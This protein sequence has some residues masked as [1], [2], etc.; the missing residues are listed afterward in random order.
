M[1]LHGRWSFVYGAACQ[2]AT[3][4]AVPGQT[5][6][7]GWSASPRRGRAPL[8]TPVGVPVAAVLPGARRSRAHR[9]AAR[10]GR[11]PSGARRFFRGPTR[12]A[13][14]DTATAKRDGWDDL[15]DANLDQDGVARAGRVIPLEVAFIQCEQHFGPAW[16]YAPLRWG[17]SDGCVPFT[18][19][20]AY[21]AALAM[22][23]ARVSIDTAR[24]IGL[25][26]GSEDAGKRAFTAAV[27]E[28]FPEAVEG[29]SDG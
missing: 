22:G 13:D 29:L 20:W 6:G 2:R 11:A 19:V 8:V 15:A 26:F 1:D 14:S 17:T 7:G 9:G 10:A 23:R 12:R 5:E 21:F 24:G 27:D 28:A 4:D 25:A 16:V 18:V 3:G